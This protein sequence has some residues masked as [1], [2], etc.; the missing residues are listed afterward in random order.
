[1]QTVRYTPLMRDHL[2]LML[3]VSAEIGRED[4]T[5]TWEQL[6]EEMELLINHLHT[7][8]HLTSRLREASPPLLFIVLNTLCPN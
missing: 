5:K 6:N 1:M 3:S 7:I 8:R 4:A 2:K